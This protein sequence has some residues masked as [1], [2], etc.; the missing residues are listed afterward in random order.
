MHCW[1]Y[2]GLGTC[3][4]GLI[5]GIADYVRLKDD[6]APP[7]WTRGGKHW[8]EGYLAP[9]PGIRTSTDA[10]ENQIPSYSLFPRVVR[11][12]VR[13]GVCETSERPHEG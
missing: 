2:N 7:H 1:Q 3:P 11:A 6:L 13:Y 5:E 8:D 4:G 12:K 10:C 9:W